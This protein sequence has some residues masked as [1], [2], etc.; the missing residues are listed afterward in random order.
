MRMLLKVKFHH[1]TFNTAVKDGSVGRKMKQILDETKPEATYFTELEGHRTAILIVDLAD[2]SKIPSLCEPW[3]L[4]FQA[5]CE[6]R[7]VMTQ[8][9]LAKAGLDELGK[10]WA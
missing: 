6:L 9:D 2:T 3:F 1:D 4:H 8:A 7:P 10:K 5:D